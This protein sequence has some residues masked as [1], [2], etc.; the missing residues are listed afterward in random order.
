MFFPRLLLA[1]SLWSPLWLLLA[2]SCSR[3]QPSGSNSQFWIHY[4]ESW[5]APWFHAIVAMAL[6]E[7]QVTKLV[8]SLSHFAVAFSVHSSACKTLFSWFWWLL[9]Q[10]QKTNIP[11]ILYLGGRK[12]S[13][14]RLAVSHPWDLAMPHSKWYVSRQLFSHLRPLFS[15]VPLLTKVSGYSYSS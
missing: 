15:V 13:P 8:A 14:D 11:G 1:V 5:K 12:I 2:L 3:Y 9:S 6:S 7:P 4:S 10:I